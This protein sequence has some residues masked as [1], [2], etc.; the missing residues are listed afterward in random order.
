M[1]S[2]SLLFIRG[3]VRTRWHVVTDE[4]K[5]EFQNVYPLLAA[6]LSTVQ[7]DNA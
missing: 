4:G 7:S 2:L 5:I 1:V 6:L 3:I